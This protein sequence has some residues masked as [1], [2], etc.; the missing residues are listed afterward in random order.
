MGYSCIAHKFI[1]KA[2]AKEEE[3]MKKKKKKREVEKEG[4]KKRNVSL[5]EFSPPLA[6]AFFPGR[7][8]LRNG[9]SR[10]LC[11]IGPDCK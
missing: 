4:K 7:V 9:T 11:L 3:K 6:V 10:N 5:I 8:S 2:N 1:E